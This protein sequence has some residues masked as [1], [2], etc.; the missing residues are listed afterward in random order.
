M[1]K[2]PL[3]LRRSVRDGIPASSN[4]TSLQQ[5]EMGLIQERGLPS[6]PSPLYS[7]H[8]KASGY[9]KGGL[10]QPAARK[11][12]I[13]AHTVV[14]SSRGL[15]Q[16]VQSIS[17]V[18]IS[19]DHS[20]HLVFQADSLSP[21]K[22]SPS[23]LLPFLVSLKCVHLTVKQSNMHQVMWTVE[24]L[25]LGLMHDNFLCTTLLTLLVYLVSMICTVF[26]F[27]ISLSS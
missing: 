4:G 27:A 25:D 10:G 22:L 20:L 11:Q 6:S 21:G 16:W 26:L 18:A 7:P 14:D 9:I 13:G 2:W 5:Q 12:L 8:T 3:Q 19:V 17:F 1:K 23:P 15:L 24:K